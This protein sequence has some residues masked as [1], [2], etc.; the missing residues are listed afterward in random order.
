MCWD[1]WTDIGSAKVIN[2]SLLCGDGWTGIGSAKAINISLLCGDGWSITMCLAASFISLCVGM[3]G[4]QA[5]YKRPF[6]GISPMRGDDWKRSRRQVD[7]ELYFPYMG[8]AG[9]VFLICRFPI[10]ISPVWG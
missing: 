1:D 10:G 6:E 8:I 5:Y 2:I 9:W 4:E 7:N 3:I